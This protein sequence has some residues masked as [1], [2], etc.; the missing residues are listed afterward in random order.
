MHLDPEHLITADVQKT[1]HVHKDKQSVNWYR[2]FFKTDTYTKITVEVIS[3]NTTEI[4]A[5]DAIVSAIPKK[6]TTEAANDK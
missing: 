3:T 1:L 5:L 4:E 2:Y 6:A